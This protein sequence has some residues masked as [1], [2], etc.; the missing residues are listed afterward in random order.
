MVLMQRGAQAQESEVTLLL[1]SSGFASL[2]GIGGGMPWM[3]AM[4]RQPLSLP[5][6]GLK[7]IGVPCR[8]CLP[9]TKNLNKEKFEVQDNRT[10]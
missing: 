5:L 4:A 6:T 10:L 8:C 7:V 2:A 9:L 1:R 3:V